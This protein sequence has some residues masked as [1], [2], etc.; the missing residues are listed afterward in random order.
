MYLNKI[1][2]YEYAKNYNRVSIVYCNYANYSYN[3]NLASVCINN[4]QI[5]IICINQFFPR[6][7]IKIFRF[8]TFDRRKR[9]SKIAFS[10]ITNGLH[11]YSKLRTL[12]CFFCDIYA[13]YMLMH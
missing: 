3:G 10:R 8:S 7:Y 12:R 5:N 4:P 9:I 13:K 6:K 11:F 2:N 1:L